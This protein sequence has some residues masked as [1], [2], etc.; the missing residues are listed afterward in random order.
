MPTSPGRQVGRRNH[1]LLVLGIVV[2][3]V[4]AITV[5]ITE[6]SSGAQRSGAAFEQ[7]STSLPAS[8][9]VPSAPT[10]SAP[11]APPGPKGPNFPMTKLEPGQ[12]PPQFI[13]FSFDGAGGHQK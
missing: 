12:K 8:P 9:S 4:F 3:V 5:R 13:I 1:L 6:Q 7:S 10:A 11:T 2:V